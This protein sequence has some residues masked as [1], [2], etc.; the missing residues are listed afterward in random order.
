MHP[1]NNFTLYGGNGAFADRQKR[2]FDQ[3]SIAEKKCN[4]ARNND[5][6]TA[7][8][9]I[10]SS[11]SNE[12]RRLPRSNR[13]HKSETRQFRG[14]ESI[15]KRPEGPAPRNKCHIIPDHHRNP[16]KWMK[17]SL[18]DV[19]TNDMT[20]RSN[21]R[22]AFAFLNELKAR[23]ARE[24]SVSEIKED[25]DSPMATGEKV[26]NANSNGPRLNESKLSAGIQFKKPRPAE[27][28][29]CQNSVVI[30][31]REEKPVFLSTKVLMPEYVVGQKQN[32]R[33]R[34]DKEK[35]G[36]LAAKIVRTKELK[37]NH[38]EELDDE[39]EQI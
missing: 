8:M 20:D 31:A 15:F 13:K 2:L 30:V 11:S 32:Q 39:D 17:Y 9:D 26:S 38:L 19:S 37:L 5:T 4:K 21:A 7:P 3:L 35:R 24:V 36:P 23:R 28:S 1:S 12:G 33:K 27:S 14:K 22:T 29:N 10:E 18:D 34:K 16:H 6:T 25:P